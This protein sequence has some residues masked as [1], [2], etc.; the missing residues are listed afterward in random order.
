MYIENP[1]HEHF[2]QNLILF[3]DKPGGEGV[4]HKS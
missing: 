4:S 2:Q 1:Y 3:Q